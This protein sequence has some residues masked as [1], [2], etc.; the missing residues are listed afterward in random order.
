MDIEQIRR[1]V[2]LVGKAIDEHDALLGLLI[3][4]RWRHDMIGELPALGRTTQKVTDP[5][6]G[7][8]RNVQVSITPADMRQNIEGLEQ[9][10]AAAETVAKRFTGADSMDGAREF[11]ADI[12]TTYQRVGSL[13]ELERMVAVGFGKAITE[14]LDEAADAGADLATLRANATA[15]LETLVTRLNTNISAIERIPSGLV[16]P[17]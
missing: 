1:D 5:R 17:S 14:A 2:A 6:T 15:K 8:P 7:E 11:Y 10:R 3:E 12:L 9:Q 4:S 16:L 13:R